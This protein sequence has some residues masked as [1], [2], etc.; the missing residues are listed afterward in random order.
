M[1]MAVWTPSDWISPTSRG[2][3]RGDGG[4]DPERLFAHQGFAGE[5]QQDA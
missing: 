4:I 3:L 5:F 1:T 2:D